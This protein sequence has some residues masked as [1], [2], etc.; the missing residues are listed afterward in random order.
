MTASEKDRVETAEKIA[1]IGT[2]A[3]FRHRM[4]WRRQR[5]LRSTHLPGGPL[6]HV[7]FAPLAEITHG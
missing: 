6:R 4:A 7:L 5:L 1:P 3:G 2:A